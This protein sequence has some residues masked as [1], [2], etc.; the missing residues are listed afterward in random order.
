MRRF[1]FS[2]RT[3]L[4][5]VAILAIPSW[6]VGAQWRIVQCRREIRNEYEKKGVLFWDIPMLMSR[7]AHDPDI[8]LVRRWMGD[9]SMWLLELP[10]SCSDSEMHEIHSGFPEADIVKMRAKPN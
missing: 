1:Q 4:I 8:P 2:L 6:Y 5:F 9:K 3:L 10:E 7:T